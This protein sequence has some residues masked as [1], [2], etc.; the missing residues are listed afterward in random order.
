MYR[1]DFQASSVFG[2]QLHIEAGVDN[3]TFELPS[4]EGRGDFV[5]LYQ[6]PLSIAHGE[7]QCGA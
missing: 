2:L 5:S 3:T 4:L 7:E 1:H 6:L